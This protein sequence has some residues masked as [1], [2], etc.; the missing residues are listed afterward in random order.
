MWH[1]ALPTLVCLFLG[2]LFVCALLFA[3]IP[4]TGEL[5][6]ILPEREFD[7]NLKLINAGRFMIYRA[8]ALMTCVISIALIAVSLVSMRMFVRHK[9]VLR[10]L[11]GCLASYAFAGAMTIFLV[12][13]GMRDLT[14]NIR[15]HPV[16]GCPSVGPLLR[17]C[18]AEPVFHGL[19]FGFTT[20]ANV[21]SGVATIAVVFA[22]LVV[23]RS[24][25]RSDV[26]V[27][28]GGREQTVMMLLIGGSIMVV[29]VQLSDKSLLDWA[30]P[31]T[32]RASTSGDH[33]DIAS[34]VA[35]TAIFNGAMETTLLGLTWLASVVFLDFDR[36]RTASASGIE[37]GSG[38]QFSIYNMS[39]VSAP[40]VTALVSAILSGRG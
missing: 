37:S 27:I 29:F 14:L 24:P 12:G 9:L 38:P 26:P 39:A 3:D 31:E 21:I 23:A 5:F 2:V 28:F 40:V 32:G 13:S 18:Q 6:G 10:T 1:Y 20:W 34:Y 35:G 22:I 8:Y 11:Y 4:T 36:R 15:G 33:A 19:H 25:K 17:W 30:F 7:P 16:T